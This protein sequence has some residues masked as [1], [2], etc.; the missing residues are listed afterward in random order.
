VAGCA[1]GCCPECDERR[2]G[3]GG[4]EHVGVEVGGIA[5][6][7]EDAVCGRRA[8]AEGEVSDGGCGATGEPD[9]VEGM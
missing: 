7:G 9:L 5:H 4:E 1:P 3:G 2:A 6:A 8:A